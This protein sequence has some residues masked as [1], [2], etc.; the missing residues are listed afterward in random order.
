MKEVDTHLPALLYGLPRGTSERFYSTRPAR[1]TSWERAI[2]SLYE[3][4]PD[5]AVKS[6]EAAF[7]QLV[8]IMIAQQQM[9]RQDRLD[10]IEFKLKEIQ[11]EKAGYEMEPGLTHS[12]SSA[13]REWGFQLLKQRSEQ[14]D[15]VS[16]RKS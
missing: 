16:V 8:K 11:L 3:K 9:E 15:F 2:A 1:L 5:A 13:T 7:G 10:V 14:R 12:A 4:A 6:Q